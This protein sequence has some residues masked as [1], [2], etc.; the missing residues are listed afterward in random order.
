VGL[1]QGD[2]VVLPGSSGLPQLGLNL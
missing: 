2:C 1:A